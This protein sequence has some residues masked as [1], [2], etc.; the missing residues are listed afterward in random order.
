MK[1]FWKYVE[2]KSAV[3]LSW[4]HQATAKLGTDSH[5]V[6]KFMSYDVH[7]TLTMRLAVV[8]LL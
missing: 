1:T 3:N 5:K 2:M 4:G 8:T 6:F 7:G